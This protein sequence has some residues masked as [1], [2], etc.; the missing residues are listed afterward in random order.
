MSFSTMPMS[1]LTNEILTVGDTTR[2]LKMD[3]EQSKM[4]WTDIVGW[5]GYATAVECEWRSRFGTMILSD[6]YPL[7]KT[8][9]WD[10]AKR[11]ECKQ[12]TGWGMRGES[13]YDALYLLFASGAHI[14]T[15]LFVS[16]SDIDSIQ[17]VWPTAH[18]QNDSNPSLAAQHRYSHHAT[19][20]S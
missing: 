11:V 10:V 4:D 18:G 3:C 5:S 8:K 15:P 1:T 13:T 7:A 14:H 6:E 9:R 16:L 17:S 12:G 2:T 20:R 19:R